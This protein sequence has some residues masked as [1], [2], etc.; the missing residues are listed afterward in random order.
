MKWYLKRCVK[1]RKYTLQDKCPYCGSETE[2]P[3]PPRF[4]PEDR[5]VEYR[6]KAK[7]E[8]NKMDLDRKPVY[9]MD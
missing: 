6:I 9:S 2:T 1:C 4:S 7:L 5:Y 3:H 8:S